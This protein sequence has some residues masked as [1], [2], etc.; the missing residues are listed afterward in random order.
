[1]AKAANSKRKTQ[2]GKAKPKRAVALRLSAASVRKNSLPTATPFDDANSGKEMLRSM[3][4]IMKAYIELPSRLL[5]CRTPLGVWREQALLAGR[6]F[7]LLERS[8][9]PER[10]PRA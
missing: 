4:G 5:Q 2:R 3:S 1:M 10:S 9:H 6:V 7:D 8:V